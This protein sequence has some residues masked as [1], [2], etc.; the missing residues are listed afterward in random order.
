MSRLKAIHPSIISL[1][2]RFGI[3]PLHLAR[4]NENA[5]QAISPERCILLA[6]LKLLA[7]ILVTS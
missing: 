5:N 2:Q 1:Q 4:L 6:L 7:C 3:R